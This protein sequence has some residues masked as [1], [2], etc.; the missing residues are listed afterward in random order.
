MA[1]NPYQVLGISEGATPEEIKSAY[2]KRAKEVHPDLHPDDPGAQEKMNEVN[3]AYDMLSNPEK[4]SAWQNRESYQGSAPRGSYE[5][6]YGQQTFYGEDFWQAMFNEFYRQQQAQQAQ[7]QARYGDQNQYQDPYRVHYR[8][9]R[10]SPLR[11]I[12]RVIIAIIV[13]RVI[14]AIL[15]TLL[16]A[17]MV[18]MNK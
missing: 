12:W 18:L 15:F 17:P 11:M 7:Y 1:K 5:N 14:R 3:A 6:P 13:F 4:Y 8:R 2:R 16:Y 10:F 9:V